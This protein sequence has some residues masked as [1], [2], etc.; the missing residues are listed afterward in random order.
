[1][2]TPP[3]LRPAAWLRRILLLNLTGIIALTPA[4]FAAPDTLKDSD[5]DEINAASAEAKPDPLAGQFWAA[6]KLLQSRQPADN[7]A[8]RLALDALA[9]REYPHAQYLLGTCLLSG[10]SGYKK[11]ARKAANQI[12]LA[13]E[14]GNAFAM[15]SLAGCYVSGT[16]LGKDEAK[17]LPL[18][19]AALEPTANYSQPARPEPAA[20]DPA[21]TSTIAGVMGNDPVSET[22]AAAHLL[23]GQILGRKNEIAKAQ[24]HFVAAATAGVDG[25]SGNY[26]AAV[27]AALNYAFGQGVPRDLAKANAMLDQ[28][29]KLTARYGVTLIH[30]YANLKMVDE[31]AV[32]DLEQNVSEAGDNLQNALQMQ[33]A[34]LLADRK[35]K[36]YNPAEAAKWYELAAAN[37]QA[38]AM[39]ELAFIHVR[40]DL[41]QADPAKAF[42]WFEKAGSGDQPKHYLGAANLA[43]C[44]AN[45]YGTP[46]DPAKA[47]AL[48]KRHRNTE[49]ICYLGSIGECPREPM[50][51]AQVLKFTEERA[52]KKDPAAQYFLGLRYA[53]GQ[54]LAVDKKK[55]E[56]WFKKSAEANHGGALCQLGLSV[57]FGPP[58]PDEKAYKKRLATAAEF[59]RKGGLAGNVDAMANYAAMLADGRGVPKDTAQ[60]EAYYLNCLALDPNHGRAHNNLASL[61]TDKLIKALAA[62]DDKAAEPLRA[63]M[64]QHLEASL[65]QKFAY[66]ANNL[67]KIY[68]DGKLVQQDYGKAYAYFE[69]AI[70]LGLPLVH[71]SLGFMHEVGQGMPVTYTE[72]AYHYRLAALEGHEESLRRLIHFYLTGRGVALDL[73]RAVFWLQLKVQRGD[74]DAIRT[75][76]DVL[77]LKGDYATLIPILRRILDEVRDRRLEGYAYYRMSLCYAEGLGVKANA[78]RAATYT[79]KAIEFGNADA[80]FDLGEKSLAAGKIPDALNYINEASRVSTRAMFKLGQ[81]YLTG[82]NVP[83]NRAKGL[84]LIKQAAQVNGPGAFPFIAN[85]SFPRK[86]AAL[87]LA[88][89]LYFLANLTDGNEPDAPALEEAIDYTQQ[90][91]NLGYAKAAALREKLE[92][93]RPKPDS[94]PEET[95]RPRT[96]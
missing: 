11:D 61:Y 84:A 36:D 57:E 28:S 13:A 94:A 32:A 30:N 91:E 87:P 73:D 56:R 81:M 62:R 2:R 66:A 58:S 44:Y 4:T 1:M 35:S 24:E 16:G 86:A 12:R 33:I 70:E 54:G 75:M 15:V 51:Y 76:C 89:A 46:R 63:L 69:Q 8:G 31:F 53:Y 74:M 18:L 20:D 27:Q 85:V 10:S 52:G 39:L 38:W 48:F 90:A 71:F 82:E 37:G 3:A 45:G 41:G 5:Q 79:Q 14:R 6:V 50:S 93:R 29:R 65:A 25:R 7:T 9:A 83:Q 72:A 22:Q 17:A 34:N 26:A 77:F 96:S 42:A 78:R 64:L 49:F 47:E 55:A 40:G 67:G 92:Q 80:I 88:Q 95:T 68:Y 43:I 59:Y 19:T 23:L 21:P 60:A